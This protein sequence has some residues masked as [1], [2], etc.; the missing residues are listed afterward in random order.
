MSLPINIHALLTGQVIEWDRLE[1]KEGWNP[2]AVGKTICAFA[3]DINNWGGGYIVIGIK[4]VNHLPELPPVGLAPSEIDTIQKELIALCNRIQ[5]VY[6]PVSAPV[7][8]QGKTVF[9]IWVPGGES[10]PYAAPAGLGK[11]AGR[12]YYV[13][14]GSSTYKASGENERKLMELTAKIPFDDRIHHSATI[15]DISLPILRSF[16][17]RVGSE[18]FRASDKMPFADLLRLMRV[19]RGPDEFLRPTNVG[20]LFFN[21]E[22]HLFFRGAQIEIVIFEDETGTNFKEKIITGPLDLQIE[23]ALQYIQ[24]AVILEEAQKEKGQIETHRFYNFPLYSLKEIIANAVY[25]KSYE[26]QNPIEIRVF[27]N[28]MEILSYPGPMPPV[29]QKH[30]RD[31]QIVARDYRNRKVGDFL[32]ELRITEGRGTG[33]PK[34]KA[35]LLAN[36]SPE[37]TLETDEECSFFL[38]TIPIHPFF[39]QVADSDLLNVSLSPRELEVLDFCR[40][41]QRRKAILEM[42]GLKNQTSNY[43]RNILPLVKRNLLVMTHAER[44]N[45]KDQRYFTNAS[46][47]RFLDRVL[48]KPSLQEGEVTKQ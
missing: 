2:L 40:T 22:P 25:H 38:V 31:Q 16:L 9:V 17:K 18:L 44:P 43:N 14:R 34:S 3:N 6:F 48:G 41:P 7:S 24:N 39:K 29:T 20:L 10:R 23:D 26:R 13:R 1:F 27:P 35:I 11:E 42:T 46:C 45:N 5:P 30:L 33:I 19:A 15:E 37:Q 32:K 12:E 8:F 36:G 28:R 21:L 4:E 47:I